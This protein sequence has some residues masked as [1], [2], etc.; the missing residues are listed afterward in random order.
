LSVTRRAA[1]ILRHP[2][3]SLS[4]ARRAAAILMSVARRA[5]A[6]L[7]EREHALARADSRSAHVLA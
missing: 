4:V 3:A 2:R 1:A 7:R 6:I 5:A